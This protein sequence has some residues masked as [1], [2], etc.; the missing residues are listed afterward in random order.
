MLLAKLVFIVTIII[1]G[2]IL[3]VY[4][5]HQHNLTFDIGVA[6]LKGLLLFWKE[7]VAS[8]HN[9]IQNRVQ[10]GIR[11]RGC[12]HFKECGCICTT[13]HSF[14]LVVLHKDECQPLVGLTPN[15]I[16]GIQGNG[17]KAECFNT[18]GCDFC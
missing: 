6:F 5:V 2:G 10:F 9:Q 14:N 18:F 13:L 1:C 8:P 3:L 15:C 11:G 16:S 7:W 12:H 4:N 17:D